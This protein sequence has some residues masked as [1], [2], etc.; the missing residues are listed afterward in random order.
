VSDTRVKVGHHVTYHHPVSR[1][2]RSA[3]VLAVVNPTTLNLQ[4]GNKTSG[5][6]V[7]GSTKKVNKNDKGV[8]KART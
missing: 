7:N 5:Y 6:V 1:K 2:P 3:R 8:W 4:I